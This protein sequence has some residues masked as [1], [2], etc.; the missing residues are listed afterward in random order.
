MDHFYM[1]AVVLPNGDIEVEEFFDMNGSYNGFE[2]I[3]NFRN[4]STIAFNE[5]GTSFG[6]S[7]IH[8][9][10]GVVIHT[11]KGVDLKKI[12]LHAYDLE[13]TFKSVEK[14]TDTFSKVTYASKGD[15]G[16]YTESTSLDGIQIKMYNDNSSK[17]FYIKYT[18]KNMGI[19]HQDVAEIGWNIFSTQMTESVD[20]FRLL[21]KIPNN[22]KELRAWA[23]GPLTGN[24]KPVNK[25]SVLVDIRGIAAETAMDTRIVFDKNI[26]STSMKQTGVE[27]LPRILSYETEKAE[28]ANL[29]REQARKDVARV[30]G[31][32]TIVTGLE[33]IWIIGL[34]IIIIVFYKKYD[35]E[36]V[37][38]FKGKYFRDFPSDISP[39]MVGYL[40]NH[41]IGTNDLSAE[42]LHLIYKRKVTYEV[43]DKDNYKLT[44][45][46]TV[47]GLNEVE[48]RA[49]KILFKEG[50]TETTLQEFQKRAK[51]S[52]K[53]FLQD[54]EDWKS[55][56]EI[57]GKKQGFFETK[58]RP[59]GLVSA[60]C[61]LG[62]IA[63][64][65]LINYTWTPMFVVI[66]WM[67]SIGTLFYL[68]SFYRRT[69]A[70]N[71]EYSKWSGLRNFINDFGQ[72]K[73]RELPQ[74]ELWEKYLVYAVT[75]GIAE[76]L[77]K[78][79]EIKVKEYDVNDS[80]MYHSWGPNYFTN[81]LL[82]NH[83]MNHSVNTAHSS[84]VS[85]RDIANSSSSSSGGFG[86]GFSGGGGSFGGGGGGGRF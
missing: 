33:M 80:D 26:L 83:I 1:K 50:T 45:S 9:G 35:K 38:N 55:Y 77:A 2:R 49:L 10:T 74:I 52:Y 60:Y 64:L 76:K 4:S 43:I 65:F 37:P 3:I 84:A 46:G 8:N 25:D 81:M 14:N 62:M 40:M 79:M 57:E 73:Q 67:A 58:G 86:G 70:G 7:S 24:V 59:A 13:T 5:N 51:A 32:K 85:A 36:Y 41:R 39:E 63:A 54:Y 44:Y 69:H 11:V 48:T 30:N 23:H 21:I 31:I 72:F 22:Q 42:I 16:K 78:Q 18:V 53:D 75:F 19:V 20:D 28:K 29:E 71:E 68:G 82:F 6:G 61:V 34:G 47:E 17:G 27:A 66:I 12:Q 56:A 15:Y